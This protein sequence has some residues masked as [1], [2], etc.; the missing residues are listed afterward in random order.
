[1]AR[2]VESGGQAL[3]L[4]DSLSSFQPSLMNAREGCPP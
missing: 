3:A 1:M 2:D 4:A